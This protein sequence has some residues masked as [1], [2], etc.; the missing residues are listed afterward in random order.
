MTRCEH[1]LEV[2]TKTYEKLLGT[3]AKLDLLIFFNSTPAFSG[4]LEELAS[5]IGRSPSEVE[6]A[7]RDFVDLGIVKR[8]EVYS[9]NAENYRELQGAISRQ[10]VVDLKESHQY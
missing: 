2:S 4:T 9:L 5:R 8:R 1:A 6:L 3:D 7:I 10:I